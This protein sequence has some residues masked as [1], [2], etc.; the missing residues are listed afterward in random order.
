MSFFSKVTSGTR[1]RIGVDF[2]TYDGIFQGSRSHVLGLFSEVIRLAPN[3]DF[4]FFLENTEDLVKKYPIFNA[5]NVTLVKMRHM[6]G[7]VRLVVQL[8]WLR[9]RHKVDLL[10]LQYRVPPLAAGPCACTIHDVLFE[11]YPQYFGKAFVIQ[12][13]ISFRFA[14]KRATLLFSVSEFS[15]NDIC[16]NYGVAKEKVTVIYNAYDKA[17]FFP[18]EKGKDVVISYDLEPGNYILTVGRLEPRKNH[19]NIFRAYAMLGKDAPPLV[20]VG[21]RDFGYEGMQALVESLGIQEKIRFFN[22]VG[23]DELPAIMRH[24]KLF[25]FPAFAEGFGMPVIEAMASGTAVITSNT[26]S[27]P[28]VS[29]NAAAFVDPYNHIDI[30]TSMRDLLADDAYCGSLVEAGLLQVKRFDW[31]ESATKLVRTYE[32]YFGLKSTV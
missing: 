3:F 19:T 23:D 16:V 30:G 24:A 10:H 9:W 25:V 32:A 5:N 7:L 20:V 4:V 14:A 8:P 1:P 18:G 22:S 26:T 15:R 11:N 29:G 21:Q 31:L 2:H 28:E 27:L 17:R 12:S 13:R 6:P